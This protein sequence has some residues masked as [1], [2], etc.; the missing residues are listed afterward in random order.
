MCADAKEFI[1]KRPWNARFEALEAKESSAW[2]DY[3]A[4]CEWWSTKVE[5]PGGPA[6]DQLHDFVTRDENGFAT[7]GDLAIYSALC[8][9]FD[10]EAAK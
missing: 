2:N 9:A 10:K 6:V 4:F 7:Y 8:D 3:A 1:C 5:E